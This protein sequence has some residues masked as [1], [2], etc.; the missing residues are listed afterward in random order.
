VTIDKP[1]IVTSEQLS[2]SRAWITAVTFSFNAPLDPAQ[3]QNVANDGAFVISAGR[4]GAFGNAAAGSTPIRSAVYN[5]ANRTVTLIPDSPLPMNHLERIVVDGAANALLNNG[6]TDAN[7]NILAGSDGAIGTPFVATFGTGTR[8]AY[9]DGSGNVVT[10]RLTRSGLMELFQAPGGDIQQLTLMGTV[11]NKSTLTGTVR[12]GARPGRA[13]LPP[14][15]GSAGV[16]IRLKPPAFISPRSGP[17]AIAEA[18]KPSDLRVHPALR[19]PLPFSR[20]PWHR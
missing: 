12:R 20:R 4:G 14:I 11:P 10:L 8:L 6:L 1:L 15:T 5:P 9:T 17:P 18:V 16:R 2:T 3:A 19:R 13:E 7:G